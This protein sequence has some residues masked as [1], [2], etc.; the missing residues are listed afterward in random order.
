M[1]GRFSHHPLPVRL[2]RAPG[3]GNRLVARQRNRY[4]DS[5]CGRNGNSFSGGHGH[6]GT[7]NGGNY[8]H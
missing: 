7:R 4:S 2:L 6:S 1:Y 8:T 5:L 3:V